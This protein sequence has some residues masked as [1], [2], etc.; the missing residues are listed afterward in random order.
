MHDM[1]YTKLFSTLLDSTVWVQED[2]ETRLV[3]ITL[4]VKKDR[5]QTVKASVPG[6]AKAAGVSI[7][8]C[9]RALERLG[10]PDEFSQSK[11][12]DGRRIREVEGGWFIVNGAK[13]RDAMSA[14]DRREYQRQKQAEYR[15]RKWA[16]KQDGVKAGAQQAIKEGLDDFRLQ[17]A[18]VVAQP[19][20][21]KL[22]WV[23]PNHPARCAN[24]VE[25]E[26]EMPQAPDNYQCAV[27]KS[28]LVVKTGKPAADFYG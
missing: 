27:C 7:E 28:V 22:W 10:K 6:L 19:I 11:E 17:K 14:D 13:Y 16:N 24:S 25:F 9:Q 12:E 15:R 21:H 26:A 2:K 23:C 18:P 4:L 5:S 8:E 3:W 20:V 1:G